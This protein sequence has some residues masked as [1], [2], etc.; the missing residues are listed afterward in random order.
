MSYKL[1]F[2]DQFG[3]LG[4]GQH[5]LLET[6]NSLDR[7]QYR[8]MVA[9]G[10][11]G[12][13]RKRLVDDGIPV[14]ELPLGRYHS[15]E[16][17][18]I[19]MLRFFIRSLYCAFVLT[20]WV[21]LHRM[22]LLFANG[23]RTFVCVTL[24]GRFTHR[25]VIWHLHNVLPSGVEL[26]LLV[27]FSRW[28]HTI[29]VCSRAVA[30]PLLEKRPSLC[31]KVK[32]LYNPVPRLNLSSPTEIAELRESFSLEAEDICIG[33]LGRITPFKGQLCFL[34]AAQ[35]VLQQCQRA[36]FFVIGDP[37]PDKT[38]QEYYRRLQQLVLQAGMKGS[39]F[40]VGHQKEVE[41]YLQM[42]DVI[43]VASQGPEAL[44]R[45]IIEA[46]FLGKAVIAP[47]SGGVMEILEDGKT[48]RLVEVTQPIEVAAS[49]LELILNPQTRESLGLRAKERIAHHISREQFAEEIQLTVRSCLD[50]EQ[51]VPLDMAK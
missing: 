35:L 19:D 12:H 37:A 31:T 7:S 33:I 39:V 46:M 17:T 13:F 36:R 45:A 18:L 38:D 26:N 23:P 50:K 2:L 4:G 6:L 9:L 16:K 27:F 5:V 32:L 15:G 29:L 8:M 11:C 21:V 51:V 41:K 14:V 43:V 34:Q 47:P 20:R 22:H 1:L 25:P 3:Y 30:K 42:M 40:F 44:P 48:G 24:A 49:M 28:V 10:G